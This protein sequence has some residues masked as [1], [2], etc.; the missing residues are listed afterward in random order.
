[1]KI[2]YNF[3][4]DPCHSI[5]YEVLIGELKRSSNYTLQSNDVAIE[6]SRITSGWYRIDSATGND[7]VN[8]SV[9]MMQCGTLYPLWMDG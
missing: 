1:M 3:L 6:D 9:S 7:I 8:E 5:N 4:V 2:L